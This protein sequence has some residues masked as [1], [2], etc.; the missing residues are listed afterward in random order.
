MR[1]M[2]LVSL[3]HSNSFSIS[4]FSYYR[5]CITFS[6]TNVD[7]FPTGTTFTWGFGDESTGT[8]ASATH[9]YGG[10]DTYTVTVTA[11]ITEVTELKV[12]RWM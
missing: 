1:V 4:L 7:D 3:F 2:K 6:V 5:T 8:G 9:S 10:A 12:G 11:D